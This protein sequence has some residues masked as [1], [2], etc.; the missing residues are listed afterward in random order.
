MIDRTL[1]DRVREI[2]KSLKLS[3]D[4]VANCL[5]IPRTAVVGIESG[6]RSISSDEL[7]KYSSLFSVSADELING[8][9][10]EFDESMYFTRSYAEL[11]EEDKRE[12]ASLI[13]YKKR[14]RSQLD[15]S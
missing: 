5:G 1:H 4:Y 6:I 15:G 13:E 14:R 2:R 11:C 7:Q 8:R 3:Q 10:S 12:I 9:I